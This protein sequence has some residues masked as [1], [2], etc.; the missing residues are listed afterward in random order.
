[1]TGTAFRFP[2]DTW[3]FRNNADSF[4]DRL[5]GQRFILKEESD[6]LFSRVKRTEW[7]RIQACISNPGGACYGM[8]LLAMMN[9]QGLITPAQIASYAETLRDVTLSEK[10]GSIINYHQF[11]QCLDSVRSA[12]DDSGFSTVSERIDKLLSTLQDGKPAMVGYSR[13]SD[14]FYH[15]ALAYD[16]V[17]EQNS[18]L[19]QNKTQVF[20][21][22]VKIYDPNSSE[23]KATYYLYINTATSA[24]YVPIYELWSG[25]YGDQLSYVL[26]DMDLLTSGSLYTEHT[27]GSTRFYPHM[28]LLADNCSV[29]YVA[30]SS[31]GWYNADPY[32]ETVLESY[33]LFGGSTDAA[34]NYIMKYAKGTYRVQTGDDVS[35]AVEAEMQY[36]NSIYR[37]QSNV[38]KSLIFSPEGVELQADAKPYTLYTV[39]NSV[40]ADKDF[41]RAEITGGSGG[42]M[43]FTESG[44]GW[45]LS[46]DNALTS[47]RISVENSKGTVQD[48]FAT[49]AQKIYIYAETATRIGVRFDF[50]GDGEFETAFSELASTDI[51]CDGTTNVADAVAAYRSAAEAEG[52]VYMKDADGDGLL[53]VRDAVTVLRSLHEA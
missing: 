28:R 51:N 21:C 48:V 24:W 37:V 13:F 50:D 19:I 40:P 52:A 1:M 3:S 38:V 27:V 46:S 14:H 7:E 11:L 35:G 49:A 10:T 36:E 26:S 18:F 23:D 4:T 53:T 42:D 33:G 30:K 25:T 17:M 15:C 47:L 5:T 34:H 44:A 12:M 9:E 31:D 16:Y 32:E 43:Q 41:F 8:V 45:I 29:A 2:Y 6:M 39:R 20:N 22:K